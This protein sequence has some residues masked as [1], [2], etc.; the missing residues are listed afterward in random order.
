MT[1]VLGSATAEAGD[2]IAQNARAL[3]AELLET[4]EQD[5]RFEEGLYLDTKSNRSIRIEE[6]VIRTAD[7]DADHPLNMKKQL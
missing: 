1:P 3:A 5:I 2:K 4:A 7:S 6:L